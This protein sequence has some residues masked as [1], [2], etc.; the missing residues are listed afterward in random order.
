MADTYN[1]LLGFA[2]DPESWRGMRQGLTDAA[3]R[4]I[5]GLLGAPVDVG[6]QALNLLIAGGGYVGH[7]A[8][9]L[10]SPPDLID[11][12]KHAFS[13]E[14]IGNKLQAVGAVSPNRNPPAEM[15]AG[16]LMPAAA[17]KIGGLAFRAEQGAVKNALAPSAL[18]PM[19]A[20]RGV[21]RMSDSV[22]P[23]EAKYPGAKKFVEE[24]ER[25]SEAH[26]KIYARWSG[27]EA[28]DLT[29]GAVSQDF[30]SGGRHA[31]LS[32]VPIDGTTHPIDIAKRLAEYNFLRMN[33]PKVAPRIYAGKQV[34]VDSDGYASIAPSKKLIDVPP[35]FVGHIDRGFV[36]AYEL[37]DRINA[38]K[39]KVEKSTGAARQIW[40]DAINKDQAALAELLK[41]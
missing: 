22:D 6:S 13:S 4:G 11:P 25:L 14:W 17:N 37:A 39:A 5:A 30:V 3:N 8:G 20:Q 34:G 10:D 24:V 7:K 36:K 2:K 40:Q 18:G 32:A 16:L 21:L 29:P 19:R 1:N 31:G 41:D 28:H 15:L 38:A 26:G 35:E 27:S 23:I 9:L 33:N 12:A